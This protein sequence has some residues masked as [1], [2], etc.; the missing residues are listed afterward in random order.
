M[1]APLP[2]AQPTED[3]VP[4]AL[5][6][7]TPEPLRSKLIELLGAERVLHRVLDLV[8]YASDA[9]PY[10]LVPQAVVM[11]HDAVDVAKVFAFGR[12]EGIPVTL[13]SGG[14][15]LNGQG[16][17]DGILVDVR[18]HFAGVEIQIGHALEFLGTIPEL[19]DNKFVFPGR[20]TGRPLASLQHAFELVREIAGLTEDGNVVLY[21]VRHNFGSTLAAQR[22][23]AYELM[24]AMGHKNLSTSL[25]YIHLANDGIQATTS[26]ATAS[27]SDALNAV[28]PKAGPKP[29]AKPEANETAGNQRGVVPGPWKRRGA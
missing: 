15:S 14:T 7:G 16:Q 29:D 13:R 8:R 24:R 11:A 26:K 10:R 27:I 3:R 25:R 1:I 20:K 23:E 12:R 21:T 4:E 18:R 22:V 17:T 2:P 19:V 9:S 28:K 5:A 6:G